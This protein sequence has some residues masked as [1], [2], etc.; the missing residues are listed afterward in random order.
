MATL[1]L[2]F[3]NRK[4]CNAFASC[5]VLPYQ[6]R[7]SPEHT[8]RLLTTNTAPVWRSISAPSSSRSHL[9]RRAERLCSFY[10]SPDCIR[11]SARI[12]HQQSAACPPLTRLLPH[13]HLTTAVFY[14]PYLLSPSMHALT[15]WRA[16]YPLRLIALWSVRRISS[17]ESSHQS[18]SYIPF[19]QSMWKICASHRSLSN[20]GQIW[21][22][23]S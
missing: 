9:L 16:C 10:H 20:Y 5:V 17:F 6:R 8:L 22:S 23:T 13:S 19:Q 12:A 2:E 1:T 3:V 7:P 14:S 15:C 18:P 21:S 4:T 11:L